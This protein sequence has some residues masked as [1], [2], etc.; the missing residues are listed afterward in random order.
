MTNEE[1]NGLIKND[2]VETES[3][4][5]TETLKQVEEIK[6]AV[7]ITVSA[8]VL[9]GK[10]EDLRD[11]LE[12][13]SEEVASWKTWQKNDHL[14]AIET[15]KSQVDEINSEWDNVSSSLLIRH[16]KLESLLQTVPGII[17][18]STLKSLSLRVTHLEQL[19]SQI[20]NESQTKVALKGSKRQFIISTAALGVTIVLWGVFIITSIVN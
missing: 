15:I 4:E 20:F 5:T 3:I 11:M 1:E 2:P 12:N 16:E 18:T 14:G 8:A 7:D 17:E 10:V 19:L 6:E 9:P 13:L